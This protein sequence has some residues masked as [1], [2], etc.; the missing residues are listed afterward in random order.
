MGPHS[1]NI[2]L[3]LVQLY[4]CLTQIHRGFVCN[5]VVMLK[6][7]MLLHSYSG[8]CSRQPGWGL[9]G[10]LIMDLWLLMNPVS[11]QSPRALSNRD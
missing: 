5:T 11:L 7:L 9:M 8:K 2:T 6:L 10:I 3:Q 4:R 1:S